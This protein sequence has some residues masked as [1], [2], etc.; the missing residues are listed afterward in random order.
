MT[1]MQFTCED[2]QTLV[3]YLYGEIEPAE[4]KAVDDHLATCAECSAEV[5]ALG[6]V[7]SE[8]GL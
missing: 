5:M 7:R 4:R 2:K 6:D 3:I 1:N 8:L